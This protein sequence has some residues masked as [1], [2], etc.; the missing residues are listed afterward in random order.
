MKKYVKP[1]LYRENMALAPA[2]LNA[3]TDTPSHSNGS[4]CAY[5]IVGLGSVFI[6]GN[7]ECE[8][9]GTDDLICYHNPENAMNIIFTS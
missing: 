9:T 7:T 5:E 1:T 2:I 8:Y 6:A 3:C 4:E